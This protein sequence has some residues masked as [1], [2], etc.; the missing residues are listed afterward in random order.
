MQPLAPKKLR[1]KCLGTAKADEHSGTPAQRNTSTTEHQR[2]GTVAVEW[3]QTK[4]EAVERREPWGKR[5][6]WRQWNAVERRW[7]RG[8][9]TGLLLLYV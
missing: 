1:R 3:G 5:W 4:S 6:R 9:V 2:S 7:R 8:T